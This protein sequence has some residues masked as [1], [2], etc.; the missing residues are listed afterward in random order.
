MH[1]NVKIKE[2]I[3]NDI[4]QNLLLY[5]NRYQNVKKGWSNKNGSWILIDQEYIVDWDDNRKCEIVEEFKK[6][7]LNNEGSIFGAFV[8]GRLIGFSV[9]SNMKF[10]INNQYIQLEYLH[11][12]DEYRHKGIGKKLFKLCIEK[13][14]KLNVKKIYISA[15]DSEA[16]QKF[17]LE[18][19][20][21][22]ALEVNKES[23]EREPLDR[24]MEYIIK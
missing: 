19:G 4:T 18:L 22:D 2:L 8:D 5:F 11:V 17:Y 3:F 15:N 7:L 21:K 12:S 23:V 10:G 13:A 1:K 16:T 24:Q 6:T 20:C 9:L 14:K